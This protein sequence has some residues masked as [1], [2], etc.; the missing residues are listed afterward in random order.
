H[1]TVRILAGAL[2][3]T[4]LLTLLVDEVLYEFKLSQKAVSKG[5]LVPVARELVQVLPTA[6]FPSLINPFEFTEKFAYLVPISQK[7]KP[8]G[9]TPEEKSPDTEEG[10]R[11]FVDPVDISVRE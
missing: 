3:V 9:N 11:I 8:I 2:P 6:V 5:R 7:S 4:L 10:T 1:S